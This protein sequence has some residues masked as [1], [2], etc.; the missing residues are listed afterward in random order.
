MRWRLLVIGAGALIFAFALF[1]NLTR[2]ATRNRIALDLT[3]A[4]PK[5]AAAQ[6][7][8]AILRPQIRNGET[9]CADPRVCYLN[10]VRANLAGMWE[11]SF[12]SGADLLSVYQR[13]Y[14][15]WCNGAPAQAR[16]EWAA[17]QTQ[18]ANRFVAQGLWALDRGALDSAE[19][20]FVASDALQ[21]SAQSHIGL[22][23]AW[24]ARGNFGRALEQ[25]DLAIA[26]DSTRTDVFLRAADTSFAVKQ[27][28][29][30]QAYCERALQIT[31]NDWLVWQVYGN[32]LSAQELWSR[33]EIAYRRVIELNPTYSHGN[34]G[35]GIALAR[36]GKL[37][38]ARPYFMAV[39][40][41]ETSDKQKAG[42][43]AGY[44]AALA[45]NGDPRGALEFYL[46]AA[47]LDPEN[48]GFRGAVVNEFIAAR[49][50]QGLRQW[51]D[52]R[53]VQNVP[54]CAP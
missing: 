46:R 10:G 47:D 14:A 21:P 13:G 22:A 40:Q 2:A 15:A 50:C 25:Y 26:L 51:A 53:R 52:Q 7:L 32:A 35:L 54:V 24:E 34:A 1:P 33:A 17:H 38:A 36:Q 39:M 12:A 19:E 43:L 23:R 20:W 27:F 30:A 16:A 37:D 49:D 18:I 6:T 28:A 41:Y 31:R 4:L 5:P 8:C 48:P 11:E 9:S 29:R 42:Y 44:A 45:A 3:R